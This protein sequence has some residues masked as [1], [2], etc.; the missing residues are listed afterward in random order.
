LGRTYLVKHTVR[1][2][3]IRALHIR[4]RV[5]I[6][7]LAEEATTRLEMNEIGSVEFEAHVPL[8]FDP[9]SSNR[10]TG[11]FILID[12]ATNATVG[13]GMIQEEV[14]ATAIAADQE[15]SSYA[16]AETPVAAEERYTRHGHF[17]AVLL[18]EGRPGLAARL[19]RLLFDRGFEALHLGRPECSGET[20]AETARVTRSAG[21]IVLYSG[22]TLS[23][24]TKHRLAAV[25]AAGFF[26]LAGVPELQGN[27]E[28]ATRHVLELAQSLWLVDEPRKNQEKVN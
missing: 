1:Q 15:F 26:D 11:S 27:E 22:D 3:K 12:A 7:T 25:F 14:S 10:T 28:L 2:T 24:D 16:V 23:G 19:E 6:N 21:L 4:H 5:N 17:P 9:Y 8:Y 18:L 20:F 13:A